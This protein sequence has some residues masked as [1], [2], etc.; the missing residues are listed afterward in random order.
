[1]QLELVRRASW[2]F[3]ARQFDVVDQTQK[4][5]PLIGRECDKGAADVM[6]GTFAIPGYTVPDFLE[7]KFQFALVAK[8]EPA[9]LQDRSHR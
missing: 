8:V 1:M 3:A 5:G 2:P 9:L 7:V 4:G 6:H